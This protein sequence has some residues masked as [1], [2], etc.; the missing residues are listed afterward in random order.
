MYDR[1]PC[2]DCGET[3]GHAPQCSHS[4]A[5]RADVEKAYIDII[6]RLMISPAPGDEL[7][8][9]A[10]GEWSDLHD[11]AFA[12]L[13]SAGL[14]EMDG[15]GVFEL[16]PLDEAHDPV[17]PQYDPLATIFKH[18]SVPGAHDNAIF[19]LV[20]WYEARGLS[21]HETK[22]RV[23]DWLHET[24]AW[25]RGGF[26]ENSPEEVLAKKKHVYEGPGN[27]DGYG[28]KNKAKEA[29]RVIDRHVGTEP[30]QSRNAK[31]IADS[32]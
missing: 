30:R 25:E 26:K 31:R 14:V 1:Y 24:G 13:L 11:D 28:W 17:D 12:E 7:R 16:V 19:A 21:W 10:D 20:A 9:T 2:P 27:G 22:E 8:D 4:T 23:I 3:N 29:K 18:G 32:D 5:S 6:S 15:D